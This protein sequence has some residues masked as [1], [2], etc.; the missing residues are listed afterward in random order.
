MKK[1]HLSLAIL[2]APITMVGKSDFSYDVAKA[3][4]TATQKAQD[5]KNQLLQASFSAR[6]NAA[7]LSFFNE[8]LKSL[9]G[10]LA[11]A[12]DKDK[13]GI[14]AGID[15]LKKEIEV[16]TKASTGVKNTVSGMY[17]TLQHHELHQLLTQPG[18]T[19]ADA[20]A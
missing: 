15:S 12:S 19:D 8:E 11:T 14:T 17:Q 5:A 10:K 9:E 18:Y 16:V 3:Q 2:V 6:E 4:A 13:V 7:K 20:T 1:L